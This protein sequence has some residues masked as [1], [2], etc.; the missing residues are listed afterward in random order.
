MEKFSTILLGIWREV[1]RHIEINDALVAVLPLINREMPVDRILIRRVDQADGCLETIAAVSSEPR[2]SFGSG[3]TACLPA[4]LKRIDSWCGSKAIWHRGESGN[5]GDL[6]E[7]VLLAGIE[8]DVLLGPLLIER[9]VCGVLALCAPLGEHFT[10]RHVV[11]MKTL[12]DPFSVAMENDRR[13]KEIAALEKTVEAE[14][15]SLLTKLG[16]AQVGDTIVGQDT[17]LAKVMER[18]EQ[19]ARSNVPVLIFGETGTGKEL[20]ARAVHGHSARDGQAFIRVNCGAIPSDLIDSELFGH[21]KGA[22]TGAVDVR[23]GW[24]ERA[25]GGTLFMDEIG[26]LPPAAQV[27]LL[28]ILQDGWLTRVGGQQPLHVDVRV[29]AATHQNLA[30]R[31]AEGRFREDL[32]YR[33]AVFPVALPPLR[34]RKGDIPELAQHFARRAAIRFGLPEAMPTPSDVELMNQYSWPGNVRELAAVIDRAAILGDGRRLELPH[35]LGAI[36]PPGPVE[37]DVPRATGNS[38][39]STISPLDFV[40]RRHIEQ[41]LEATRGRIEGPSGCARMLRVNSNTLRAKMRKLG[42]DW[43]TFRTP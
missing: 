32:W 13:L 5:D 20:I 8:G 1:G 14:N 43:R 7:T 12:L 21:E 4:D 16:R 27:R 11:L 38:T 3:R 33:L 15:R 6:L 37:S 17:G 9:D 19:V 42:I 40:I 35:A 2:P 22:F 34:E 25:D 30:A 29:V 18:V 31:V 39:R 36:E 26:D 23:H 24:F 28:R 41:A 10:P